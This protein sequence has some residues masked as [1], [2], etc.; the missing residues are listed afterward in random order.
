MA[1]NYLR[2]VFRTSDGR[3]VPIVFPPEPRARRVNGLFLIQ[4]DLQFAAAG[5][6]YLAENFDRSIAGDAQHLGDRGRE[7][8]IGRSLWL[9]SVVSYGKCFVEAEGR[10]IRLERT[11]V[12]S[13][14]DTLL[15]CHD[16]L[17]HDRHQHVAHGGTSLNEHSI[18]GFAVTS[19]TPLDLVQVSCVIQAVTTSKEACVAAVKL[20]QRLAALVETR[21]SAACDSLEADLRRLPTD[22]LRRLVDEQTGT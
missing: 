4:G 9:A 14:G 2:P 18:F 19:L 10:R 1:V 8:L 11:D 15:A 5:F 16:K 17:M 12:E 13:L 6:E 22:Q 21:V 20:C 3:D 7:G